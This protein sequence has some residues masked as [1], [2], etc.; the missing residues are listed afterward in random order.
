MKEA[1]EL[2]RFDD[3]AKIL[4]KRT[5]NLEN[6]RHYLEESLNNR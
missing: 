3:Q 2:R 4:D 5:P 1:V 6:F